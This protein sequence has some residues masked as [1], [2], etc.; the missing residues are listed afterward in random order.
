MLFSNFKLIDIRIY[1]EENGCS[2]FDIF[3]NVSVQGIINMINLCHKNLDKIEC[4]Q[5]L[6]DYLNSGHTLLDALN[7]LKDALLGTNINEKEEGAEDFIDIAEY[8]CLTDLYIHF[9]MQLMSVGLSYSEFWNMS[10][11]EMYKVFNS[12]AIKMQNETNRELSNYHTLAAMIG[13]AVWGK[14]QKKPPHVDIQTNINKNND[15][16]DA[17]DALL[18]SQLK[19][20]AYSH[21]KRLKEES[22]NE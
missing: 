9:S 11:V 14:L 20:F 6:D 16:M 18:V 7:E 5:L 1:E 22:N 12:I 4:A 21:N 19:A 10:T 2:V 8:K 15:D 17:D 13:G 3:K